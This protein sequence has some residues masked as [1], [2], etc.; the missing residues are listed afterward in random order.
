M[1]NW[2]P[3]AVEG[4]M[5]VNAKRLRQRRPDD[6][7]AH[8]RMSRAA[9]GR[10]RLAEQ[11]LHQKRE[12]L[13]GEAGLGKPAR[14]G[15]PIAPCQKVLAETCRAKSRRRKIHRIVQFNLNGQALKNPSVGLLKLVVDN[16]PELASTLRYS[17]CCQSQLDVDETRCDH[18]QQTECVWQRPEWGK[19]KP[20]LG[21]AVKAS[22]QLA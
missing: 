3:A 1:E 17:R 6:A 8:A 2:G 7:H 11:W 22:P 18:Q 13:Q 20:S 10:N 14:M 15:D 19:S 4:S 9:S 5:K 21:Q 12:A 16:T